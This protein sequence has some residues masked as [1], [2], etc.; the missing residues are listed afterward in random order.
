MRKNTPVSE[1]M[2][3]K[4]V[5]AEPDNAF[6]QVQQLFVEYNIHHL[7]VVYDDRLIGIISSNDVMKVYATK[8]SGLEDTSPASLDEHFS[9]DGLMT[10]EPTSIHPEEPLAKAIDILSEGKFQALPV[11]DDEGKIVGIISNKDMVRILR[12]EI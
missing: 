7:P 9:I 5:V 10:H 3:R 11:I 1:Y 4:V 2:T 12:D 8:L 6:S